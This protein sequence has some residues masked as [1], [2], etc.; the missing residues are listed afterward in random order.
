MPLNEISLRETILAVE[1]SQKF[2][3]GKSEAWNEDHFVNRSISLPFHD[4]KEQKFKRE[5][6]FS[7]GLSTTK[8]N[9]RGVRLKSGLISRLNHCLNS[10]RESVG[11]LTYERFQRR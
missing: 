6:F 11:V 8:W 10:S 2:I 5:S 1:P 7:Y 9:T 3:M 4:N